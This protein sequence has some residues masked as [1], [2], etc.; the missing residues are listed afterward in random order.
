MEQMYRVTFEKIE[1]KTKQVYVYETQNSVS[2]DDAEQLLFTA[3]KLVD[4]FPSSINIE[5]L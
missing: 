4:I 1:S 3:L 2:P 5:E